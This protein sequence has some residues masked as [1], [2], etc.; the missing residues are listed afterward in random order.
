MKLRGF[1]GRFIQYLSVLDAS[2]SPLLELPMRL[3]SF[4]ERVISN[5]SEAISQVLQRLQFSL[6]SHGGPGFSILER[7]GISSSR[8]AFCFV[9]CALSTSFSSP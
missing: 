7:G 2:T 5:F 8:L 3:W 4:G 9:L 1:W 6:S